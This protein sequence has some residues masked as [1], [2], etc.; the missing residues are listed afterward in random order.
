LVDGIIYLWYFELEMTEIVF[1]I[2][3]IFIVIFALSVHESAHAWVAYKCGDPT[4]RNL[5]RVTLNPVPHIDPIGLVFMVMIVLARIPAFGW[6]KPVPVNPYNLRN[7]RRD[8]MLVSAAGPGSNIL[9]GLIAIMV[10]KLLLN[11]DILSRTRLIESFNST[12]LKNVPLMITIELI[13][14]YFIIINFFLAVFNLLPIPPLDGSGIVAGMLRGEALASYLRFQ[15]YGFILLLG[16][17][18]FT[19]AL[20]YIFLPILNFILNIIIQ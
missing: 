7:P 12:V 2:I 5:G 1:G 16:L 3:Q 13:L 17:I 6:A 15:R 20:G 18:M 9:S 14:T 19:D 10:M 11:T 4:A 8:S